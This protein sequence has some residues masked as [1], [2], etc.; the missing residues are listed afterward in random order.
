MEQINLINDPNLVRDFNKAIDYID[1]RKH[2]KALALF[3]RVLKVTEF[4]ELWLNMGVAYKGLNN[5]EKVRECFDRAC[6]PDLPF[7]DGKFVDIWPLAVSNLGLYHYALQQDDTAAFLQ[8][9]ALTKD[10]SYFDAIWNLSLVELRKLCSNKEV[11]AKKAWEYYSWRF[12]RT[13]A[14]KLK[15]SKENL[16]FWNF[17]DAYPDESIVILVEQGMGDSIMFG[18][19]IKYVAEK[20]KKVYVQCTTEMEG[21]FENP[22]R[23]ASETDATLAVPMA[24]L[25]KVVD[26][27]PPG[28]WLR[29][30]YVPKVGGDMNILCVWSGNATHVNDHNRSTHAGYFDKLS[31]YGT[32]H[33][34]VKRKGY[35]HLEIGSWTDTI[36]YLEGIDIV[37][38]VDT[39]IVHLCGA[40]GKP[41]I[42]LMPL[43]DTDFRWGDNSM[44][45]KNVWYDSVKVI[46]NENNWEKVF[47]SVH[48]ELQSW[49]PL[50][51]ERKA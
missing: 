30:K 44:G 51:N 18:R 28:D 6:S 42:V 31:K 12:K 39:S 25:A 26:F 46:R 36:K 40:L 24:S 32:L 7:S 37:I 11:D 50:S 38:S 9:V 27:I 4:K 47:K 16:I 35:K 21:L 22:C 2:D 33:S 10:P 13:K 5:Y 20:F 34:I 14:D 19:Y 17:K 48:R 8:R 43:F 49:V 41:C 3:K 45:T 23:D 1:A 15:N 29:D